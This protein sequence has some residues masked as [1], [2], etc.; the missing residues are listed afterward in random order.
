MEMKLS[1]QDVLSMN[2]ALKQMID[3][4]QGSIDP[5]FKFRLLGIMKSLEPHILNFDMIRNEAITKYG[6]QAAD[7]SFRISPEKEESF[8]Q[9]HEELTKV[10]NSQV[11]VYLEKLTP[12]DIFNKG[13]KAEY[14]VALYPIIEG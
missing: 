9:F 11:A 14:L 8:R 6:E 2:Q 3:D 1:L 10:L 5:L 7:G 13:G 12:A 4:D